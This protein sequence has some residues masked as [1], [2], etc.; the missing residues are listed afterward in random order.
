[1]QI[2]SSIQQIQ[3]TCKMLC[4]QGG[5]IGF[6]PTMGY[7]HEGHLALMKQAREENEIVVASIFVNPLQF[8]PN[9][10]FERYPR[11][12]ERD[13][14]LASDAG[15][16]FL[17]TP[18]VEEMY[19][20]PMTTKLTVIQRNDVLCGRKRE[21][22]FDGVATVLLKLFHLVMPDNVYMGT[23]DAQQVAVVQGLVDDYHIPVK[24]ISVPTVRE[25]DGL[26]KSSRNV[27]LTK[28][29]REQAPT[30]YKSLLQAKELI[31]NGER[32][33]DNI[34]AHIRQLLEK[35]QGEIDYI[36]LYHYPSLQEVSS[37]RG[38]VIIAIAVKFSQARLIDNVILHVEGESE[39][40]SYNDARENS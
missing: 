34:L 16:D 4:K 36:E 6:V 24:I 27:Y 17:F 39:Y 5:R 38:T 28:A 1:M 32:N 35:I 30:L 37:I 3:L 29:E 23:K 12:L 25:A 40:V 21:G 14:Q 22:H 11:D 8:G 13:T 9:E 15:V 20:H 7:L 19:P 33:P 26:A 10:D 18:A 31:E 2:I